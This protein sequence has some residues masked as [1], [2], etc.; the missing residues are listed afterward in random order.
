MKFLS[1]T[2]DGVTEKEVGPG[3]D[4]YEAD[5]KARVAEEVGEI[6]LSIAQA[7]LKRLRS[8]NVAPLMVH[9]EIDGDDWFLRRFDL[10]R[11]TLYAMLLQ[12]GKDCVLD[13]DN[14]VGV[15]PVLAAALFCTCVRGE[16]DATPFFE[17]WEEAWEQA[18]D[19]S[20]DVVEANQEL[21]KHMLRLNPEMSPDAAAQLKAEDAN[22][23][24]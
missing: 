2:K 21:F 5:V 19:N 6:Q 23:L 10:D 22:P 18:E 14:S 11:L 1:L 7:R 13:S 12:R 17:S 16:F 4:L 9:V 20:P 8:K 15:T 24:V 3:D